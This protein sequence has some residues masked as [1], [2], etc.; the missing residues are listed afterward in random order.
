MNHRGP[1]ENEDRSRL[2][3][4]WF[5]FLIRSW[6]ATVEVFLHKAPTGRRW[7]GLF[8]LGG[9]ILIFFFGALFPGRDARPL[10]AYLVAYLMACVWT[11]SLTA[12]RSRRGGR[13]YGWY[14]GRPRLLTL[15]PFLGELR[16]KC[17]AEPIVVLTAAVCV[18]PWSEPLGAYL[19]G[20]SLALY[21][22]VV[23][24]DTEERV[25]AEE[26]LDQVC[27][28]RRLAERFREL[29]GARF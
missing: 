26:L 23:A 6:A 17:F 4:A 16:T 25:R 15:L 12:W 14:T 29:D 8:G 5:V 22:T 3:G 13:E 9:A 28:Q 2:L 7:P 27:M 10:L 21:V 24:A 18:L 20:A 1:D 19:L 11:R